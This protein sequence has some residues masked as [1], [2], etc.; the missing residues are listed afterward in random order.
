M[1]QCGL[2]CAGASVAEIE[3]VGVGEIDAAAS[4][5][6]AVCATPAAPG[7]PNRPAH[8]DLPGLDPTTAPPAHPGDTT[9]AQHLTY[10]LNT[11]AVHRLRATTRTRYETTIR[12]CFTG[13]G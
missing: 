5:A 8:T 3:A 13:R 1:Q 4:S 2:P 6:A 11:V 9:V 7:A 12:P 10:G